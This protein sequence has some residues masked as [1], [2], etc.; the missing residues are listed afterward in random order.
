MLTRPPHFPEQ[1]VG[2]CTGPALEN[3]KKFQK[4]SPVSPI[5][6]LDARP[7]E[8]AQQSLVRLAGEKLFRNSK[9]RM[10]FLVLIPLVNYYS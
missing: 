8:A 5:Q 9:L 3:A 10:I 7:F 6:P 4:F 2:V 1:G